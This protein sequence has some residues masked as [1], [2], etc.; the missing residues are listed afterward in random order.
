MKTLIIKW[1]IKQIKKLPDNVTYEVL[2]KYGIAD[3]NT[4]NG[5]KWYLFDL[6]K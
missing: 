4:Q 5:E 1:A 2:E 6:I 3:I